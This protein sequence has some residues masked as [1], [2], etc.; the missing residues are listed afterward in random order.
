MN[1][2]LLRVE[3]EKS[4]SEELYTLFRGDIIQRVLRWP[5]WVLYIDIIYIYF[6]Y[7]EV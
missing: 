1:Y 7:I 5:P 3:L 2:D 4:I 6:A